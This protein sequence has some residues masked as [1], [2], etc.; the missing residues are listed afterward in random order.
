[1]N[2]KNRND[3]RNNALWGRSGESRANAMWGR[4]GKNRANALWGRSGR[5]IVLALVAALTVVIPLGASAGGNRG[6]SNAHT[7]VA[8]GLLD[9]AEKN[10]GQRLHLIIQSSAG[11]TAAASSVRGLGD[12]RKQL[13]VIGAV[14]VDVPAARLKELARNPGLTITADAPIRLSGTATPYS[15]E[16][17]PYESG[18]AKLWGSPGSPAPATGTIAIVDS[19]ID[20]TRADFD[21][22]ARVLPQVTVTSRT[23]NSPGDG[24]GHGTFVA[25]IAAGSAP[26]HAGA[27][28]NARI[29]PID[30]MDDSGTALTSDVIAACNYILQ[31]KAAL[32]IRV[33]N[34]SL[35]SGAKNNFYNDPLD[36]AVEKLW[37]NGVFVVA[38]AGNYGSPNGPSGV[39][40]APGNDPFVLTVGA[41]DIGNRPALNDDNTAPWSAYG[42]TEDGFSKPEL[43]APGRYMVGAVPPSATLTKERPDHV[44]SPG[45]MELSGTSFAAPAVAGTA[46]QIIA[47][48]P[49]WTVDQIKGALMLTAKPVSNAPK[50]STGVGELNAARAAQ[51]AGT[52]P[53]PNRAIDKFLAADTTGTLS[54]DSA[55]WN[56]AVKANASWMA[57]SWG[58]ASWGEAS[59]SSASWG[60]ASWSAASWGDA[61]WGAASW[62]DA[63]WGDASWADMSSEDAAEGD[64]S[65]PAPPMDAAASAEIQ[66][67]PD[68]ALPLDQ[69]V[70]DPSVTDPASVAVSALP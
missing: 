59:W 39:L 1:M 12:V 31:N 32:N 24:R 21:G 65:G 2:S 15:N 3:M 20:A 28:P 16:M 42:Y 11:T 40:F 55:S 33:A 66:A 4:T 10:P 57:A 27:A 67:D 36:R 63:S 43:G 46:L 37:F 29:L 70:S 8:P 52:P 25:S 30:V 68:L 38:A 48:H 49:A 50:G 44:V 56:T 17:W 26:G 14:A 18:V 19:G 34:F 45:Y 61:S 69:V 62:G 58:D 47:R 54:F 13:D 64:A 53:N 35:H 51:Y 41:V 7:F 23:P 5:A 6:P 22:G 9:R 60:D